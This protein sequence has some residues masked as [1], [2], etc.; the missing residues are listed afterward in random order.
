ME[1]LDLDPDPAGSGCFRRI[2]VRLKSE[3]QDPN[4]RN[5]KLSLRYLLTKDKIK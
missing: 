5:I 1:V 3:H 2:R 4:T